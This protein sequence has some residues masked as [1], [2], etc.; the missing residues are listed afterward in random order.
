MLNNPIISVIIP[1]YNTKAQHLSTAIESVLNQSFKYLEVLVIDDCSTED[2]NTTVQKFTDERIRF[3][4]AE[5]NGGAG[6][7]RNIGLQ[8]A[9]GQ[10]IALMDSDDIALPHR[11]Q[12]EYNYMEKHSEIDV[13]GSF[14]QKF[15]QNKIIKTPLQH[16]NIIHENIFL[17]CAMNNPSVM[18]RAASQV[19]YIDNLRIAED[20]ELW[21]R[22]AFKLRFANLPKALMKYRWDGQNITVTQNDKQVT[23]TAQLQSA[24]WI[25]IAKTDNLIQPLLIRFICKETLTDCELQQISD[26][27]DRLL[28]QV[29]NH[30]QLNRKTTIKYLR[31]LLKRI[32]RKTPDKNYSKQLCSSKL[33]KQFRL[34]WYFCLKQR[35][36]RS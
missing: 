10:Y 28:Y 20:Y 36:S 30:T 27:F 14:M 13:L 32:I 33:A 24:K 23:T 5:K 4:R 34:S 21:L 17:N 2:I 18:F 8:Q 31:K 35:L 29:E 9:R 6:Q 15:P 25:E 1:V 7:A 19:H 22:Y 3:F 12:T 16:N 26:F 11:L